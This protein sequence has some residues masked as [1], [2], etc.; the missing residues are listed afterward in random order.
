MVGR[1]IAVGL[2]A[3]QL[4]WIFAL[5]L[6]MFQV[7]SVQSGPYTGTTAE[8]IRGVGRFLLFAT[9]GLYAVFHLAFALLGRRNG[10]PG[11]AWSAI[12]VAATPFIFVEFPSRMILL[13]LVFF[14]ASLIAARGVLGRA[15]YC[16]GG[17]ELAGGLLGLAFGPNPVAVLCVPAWV[18][19]YH[20]LRAAYHR[21]SP[22]PRAVGAHYGAA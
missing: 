3:G 15:G 19:K 20:V 14:G 13:T 5:V 9:A 8:S 12:A 11:L 2:G 7:S 10:I 4:F 6:V 17:L 16:A 22:R 18:L 1:A 21:E